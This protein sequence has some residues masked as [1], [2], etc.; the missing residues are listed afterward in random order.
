MS[1]DLEPIED[2]LMTPP[3]HG[4]DEEDP[5]GAQEEDEDELPA[6]STGD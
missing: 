4:E 6:E 5:E 1:E 2:D 3:E